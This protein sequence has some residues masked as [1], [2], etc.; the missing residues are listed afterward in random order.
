VLFRSQAMK[1]EVPT[2]ARPCKDFGKVTCAPS[3]TEQQLPEVCRFAN[4]GA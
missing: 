3:P 1:L 4:G 2:L